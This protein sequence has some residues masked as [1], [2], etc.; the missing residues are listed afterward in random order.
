MTQPTPTAIL[1]YALASL[2]LA[3][4]IMGIMHFDG[5]VLADIEM[6]DPVE[7]YKDYPECMKLVS[8]SL[9]IALIAAFSPFKSISSL[10]VGI[11]LGSFAFYGI[12][13]YTQLRDLE[14]MGLSS[15]P[16]ME[17]VTITPEGTWLIRMCVI[18]AAVH[19]LYGLAAPILRIK[20][21]RLHSTRR[22]LK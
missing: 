19:I 16:L 8:W 15:K 9:T 4:P 2:A 7:L 5:K 13:Q 10:G 17:M 18:C 3:L 11:A 22:R 21:N 20:K 14:E 1:K 6:G 12:D